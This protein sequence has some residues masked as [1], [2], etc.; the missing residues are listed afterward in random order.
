MRTF[1]FTLIAVSSLFAASANA[2]AKPAEEKGLSLEQ[3]IELAKKIFAKEENVAA[4]R[5]LGLIC[6]SCSHGLN[7]KFKNL[8]V[9]D[10]ERLEKG[11][12]L[13]IYNQFLTVALKNGETVDVEK[14]YKAIEDAG[15]E[16]KTLFLM[17]SVATVTGE[18]SFTISR[19]ANTQFA[20]VDAS[21]K[22]LLEQGKEH[23]LL[24]VSPSNYDRKNNKA[25]IHQAHLVDTIHES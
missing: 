13:D 23:T 21:Q 17:D 5:V 22:E 9:V 4:I 11:I 24:I 3:E 10:K 15:Y 6:E 18:R 16:P 8:K 12:K 20:L 25:E 1:I 14:L 2:I 19:S 7:I